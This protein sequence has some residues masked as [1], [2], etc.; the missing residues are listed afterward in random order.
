M[1][2][3]PSTGHLPHRLRRH[4]TDLGPSK[5]HNS[6]TSSLLPPPSLLHSPCV[7]GCVCAGEVAGG[8]G[9]PSAHGARAVEEGGEGQE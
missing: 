6:C 1:E 3:E 9:T 7:A 5:G 4:H 2:H 8:Q